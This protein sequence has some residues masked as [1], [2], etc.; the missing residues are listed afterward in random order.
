MQVQKA[1]CLLVTRQ[2][3]IPLYSP[4][5]L[6]YLCCR[7]WELRG[8]GS[9]CPIISQNLLPACAFGIWMRAQCLCPAAGQG[10]ASSPLHLRIRVLFLCLLDW[11]MGSSSYFSAIFSQICF[12]TDSCLLSLESPS[13]LSLPDVGTEATSG[14]F[15]CCILSPGTRQ[16]GSPDLL[17][18]FHATGCR[19]PPF[20]LTQL[21]T[22]GLSTNESALDSH[23]CF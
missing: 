23:C 4:R 16:N 22:V 10:A 19:V 13:V 12:P 9:H 5:L 18:L 1:I 6:A 7:S 14:Q 17:L 2:V 20:C 8:R 15:C 21:M 3:V 11:I